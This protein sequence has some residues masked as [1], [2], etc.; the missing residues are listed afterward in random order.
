MGGSGGGGGGG[1]TVTRTELDPTMRPY[2][3]YG[4]SEAQRLYQQPGM[5]QYYPGQ[6][7][8][9]PSQQTQAALQA[10]QQRAM[11]GNPLVPA[12]QQELLGTIQGQYLGGNP[13]FQGAF[14]PAAQAAE[15]QY[16]SSVNQALSNFSRAGRYGSGAMTGAL[17]Q[18]GGEFGRAL[19]GTA[20][21]LA[22][23]NYADERAKQMAALQA[24][25]QMATAD[26][27]DINR[28][29]QLGQMSEAYQESALADAINRYN[30]EQQAPYSRL[31]S[32]LS[33]AYGAPTGVQQTTPVYRNQ[34]GQA[35]GGAL[36]G[37]GLGQ[38]TGFSPAVGAVGGGLLGA[39]A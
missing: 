5:M 15:R 32:F 22:Y 30:F 37:A 3:Q 1:T 35:V 16:Q 19:S 13:F 26:Y 17:N 11:T 31:Q 25:P 23:A 10:A 6:T 28:L 12:A 21:Q 24:A 38:M 36:A 2:V 18:A 27:G 20:G 34:L 9:G 39:I 29:L 33:A 14:A 8:I 4:L 7:Y